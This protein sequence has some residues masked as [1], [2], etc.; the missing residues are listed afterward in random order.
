MCGLYA[1]VGLRPDKTRLGRVAHRG[2]DGEGWLVFDTAAG[3]L[4]LGHRRLAIIDLEPRAAQPMASPEGRYVIIF[5]GEIYNYLE[6]RKDLSKLGEA[7]ETTSDCEVLLRA[8]TVW[9]LSALDKL[10]GM[11]AFL[12]YDKH[13]QRLTI[14]RDPY[15]IKPMYFAKSGDGIAFGS[16]PKQLYDLDGIS[17]KANRARLWDFIVSQTSEHTEQTMFEG[18]MQLR[19]GHLIELDLSTPLVDWQPNPA[20]WFEVPTAGRLNITLETAASRFDALLRASIQLHLR[21]DVPVGS[22]LSGGLDSSS[23][24]GIASQQRGPDD[25]LSTFTAI[26]PGQSIDESRFAQDVVTKNASK[27]TYV[28]ISEAELAACIDDVIWHQDEPFGSTSILAQWFVFA[29]IRKSGI[30][31][32]LDGQGADEQLGGYHDLFSFHHA[33]LF[34]RGKF[35]QFIRGLLARKKDQNVPL[36]DVFDG[37]LNRVRARLDLTA[38]SEKLG[39]ARDPLAKG[40]LQ[41]FAPVEG[42]TLNGALARDELPPLET[43]GELCLAMTISSNLPMLLRFEDR[44]SMAHGVEARVPFV[45]RDLIEFTLGLGEHH[46][47]VG[48]DN[49]VV[50]RRAMDKVLPRSVLDRRDKL[51]FSTPESDWIRGGLK[52]FIYR[53]IELAKQRFPDLL[54]WSAV[55]E[56]CAAAMIE[57]SVAHPQVWRIANL[58]LWAERFDVT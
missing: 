23:I 48:S 20:R 41:S 5:N 9:G 34:R 49:K 40:N 38:P 56:L 2:P 21:A 26:F 57:G 22:C 4:T 7:F 16:E 43:L 53:G 18:V 44:N 6:I 27:P 47:L 51:G 8:L 14:A 37:L 54:D 25:P 32:V 30:K 10:R 45:E 24:V 15:G 11:F 13:S 35:L 33:S 3:P 52:P 55:D 31:V 42:S 19:P 28:E 58:G 1:S 12:M 29:A 36:L 39:Q 50:L 46:K 17:R